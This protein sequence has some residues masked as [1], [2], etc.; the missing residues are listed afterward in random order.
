MLFSKSKLVFQFELR[1]DTCRAAAESSDG[2]NLVSECL[3]SYP[4]RGTPPA[5][6]TRIVNCFVCE[7]SPLR[8]RV[9]R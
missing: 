1:S 7:I 4:L 9:E 2:S 5:N 3:Y 8:K 6:G